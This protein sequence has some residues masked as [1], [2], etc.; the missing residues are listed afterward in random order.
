MQ[1]TSISKQK[2]LTNESR[3]VIEKEL[4]NNSTFSTIGELL[5]KDPTSISKEVRRHRVFKKHNSFNDPGNKCRHYGACKRKRVCGARCP[6][7]RKLCRNC[8]FCNE[9]CSDFEA[10]DYSC[11]KLSR[12]PYVCNGC[13]DKNRCRL[14]KYVYRAVAA[15]ADYQQILV[16]AREGLNITPEEAERLDK[17][18]SPLIMQG[19]SPY[20]ILQNHPEIGLSEKTLYTYIEKGVFTARNIDMKRVKYKKRSVHKSQIKNVG[21]FNGRTYDD[22]RNFVE[23]NPEA[24]VVEMDTVHGCRGS[25]THLLTLFLRNIGLMLAYP[26]PHNRSSCVRD[27]FNDLENRLGA[28]AFRSM[29]SVILT[30]RGSEF[31]QPAELETSPDG[32]Q[33]NRIFY[34]DPMASW[35]K[36]MCEKNHEYIRKILPKGT[37]FDALTESDVMKMMSHINSAKRLKFSG[38]SPLELAWFVLGAKVVSA[39]GLEIIEPDNI[40]LTPELLRAEKE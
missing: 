36:G 19:Q 16:E 23:A 1:E 34:C 22:F 5:G 27:V 3:V 15:Q 8:D 33:R 39:L 28:E 20:L 13:P 6:T 18:I 14:D 32:S 21:I 31:S 25:S 40:V 35:Q 12:A 11:P 17:I 29:F 37:S 2:H 26:I 9:R 30:D 38:R 4:D 7:S 24:C 10:R